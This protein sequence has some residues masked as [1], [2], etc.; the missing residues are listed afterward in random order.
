MSAE[1]A[2]TRRTFGSGLVALAAA[3]TLVTSGCDTDGGLDLPGLPEPQEDPDEKQAAGALLDE[4]QILER[5]LRVQRRHRRLRS[6]LEP[7][8]DVHRAHV[9]LLSGALQDDGTGPATG[10]SSRVPTDPVRAVAELVQLERDLADRHVAT[11][12]AC[13]SGALARVVAV[14]S[15]A[16]A[17][18]AVALTPLATTPKEAG[19]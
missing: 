19:Q 12:M 16:A 8:A 18:Q 4:Q 10:L 6:A 2:L 3:T 17:Q 15:A 11:S 1:P 14:M 9:E 5:V 13:R 7:S